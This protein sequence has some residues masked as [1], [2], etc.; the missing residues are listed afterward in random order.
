MLLGCRFYEDNIIYVVLLLA[1]GHNEEKLGRRAFLNK[2]IVSCQL[3]PVTYDCHFVGYN[4]TAKICGTFSCSFIVR[5]RNTV[6]TV[7]LTNC[8]HLPE[9]SY[10]LQRELFYSFLETPQ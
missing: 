2:S 9:L 8:S 6:N 3:T 10:H 4:L 7:L 5:N 1:L